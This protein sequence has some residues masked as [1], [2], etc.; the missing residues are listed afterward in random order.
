MLRSA[1]SSR[2]I[3]LPM[4]GGCGPLRPSP[5][6][7]PRLRGPSCWLA[8]K[9]VAEQREICP[10]LSTNSPVIHT[11]SVH[12]LSHAIAGLHVETLREEAERMML[13]HWVELIHGFV[14]RAA[15]P[16]QEDDR[17]WR[18]WEVVEVDLKRNWRLADLAEIACTSPEHLRRLCQQ[19]LGRSPIQQITYLR[20]RRAVDFLTTTQDK[21]EAIAQAVGY[22]NPF[23]F[24]NAF[25][26]WTGRRPTDYREKC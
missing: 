11:G 1:N 12:G 23:T 2:V 25:K 21:V 22:E 9:G 6:F 4:W 19:Q 8:W 5:S 3:T 10:I 17:L 20:M 13:H 26:R 16:Y 24:S 7:G 15:R 18:L 14:S